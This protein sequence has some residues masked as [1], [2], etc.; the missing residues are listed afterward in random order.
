V[1]LF[2]QACNGGVCI[3][4]LGTTETL[5]SLGDRLMYRLAYR[6]FGDHEAMVVNHSVA[7]GSTVGVRWYELRSPTAAPGPGQFSLYQS[8]TFAPLDSAYRWMGSI[9]MDQAGDIAVGYSSSA[10]SGPTPHYPAI[11]VAGRT[12]A[13][14][15]GTLGGE[16]TLQPG[17]GSQTGYTRWGDYTS[18]RIDPSDDCTFWYT[19]EYYTQSASFSW[20]SFIGSFKIP[21]GVCAP[22][23]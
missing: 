8:G 2:N 10:V 19:N 14:S 23:P 6:N 11:A 15:L 13:D 20:S 1:D 12:P 21:S 18:M 9:A 7:S 5:D 4:Q 22:A 17:S 16:V 3:P